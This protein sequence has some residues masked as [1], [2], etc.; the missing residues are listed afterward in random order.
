MYQNTAQGIAS[1]GRN[2]DSMLVHMTPGEVGGLQHLA[3]AHGGSLTINPQTGLPE[4]G[5]LSNILPIAASVIDSMYG[6]PWLG[7]AI[8]G[9]ANYLQTGNLGQSIG[10]GALSYGLGQIGSGMMDSG[11]TALSDASGV[12]NAF[13]NYDPSLA[14]TPPDASGVSL[15]PQFPDQ[16]GYA[17]YQPEPTVADF[18]KDAASAPV[19]PAQE[20]QLYANEALTPGPTYTSAAEIRN[21]RPLDAFTKGASKAYDDGLGA[22]LTKN[23]TPLMVAGAGLLGSSM[24][25]TPKGVN[26]PSVNKGTIRP[27]KRITGEVNP[28]W[29]KPGNQ[30]PYY[31]GEGYEAQPIYP[32]AAGG[33]MSFAGG[34]PATGSAYQTAST[35]F[36]DDSAKVPDVSGL[37]ISQLERLSTDAE[38]AALQTAARDRLFELGVT[39]RP[40][41]SAYTKHAAHGGLMDLSNEYAAGGRLLKGPGDGMS[42]SIPA[43]I[44]GPRPQRAALAQGEFV[45]PADVVSHLGNGS[46]DA[47]AKRLYAMMDKI[48]H[49]RTGNKKQGRQINPDKFM[50]A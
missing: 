32:A 14:I 34:G 24:F 19:A 36:S 31:I 8:S 30:N 25:E 15:A 16:P 39:Q 29:G 49:A 7:A 21:E 3:M 50:P 18:Y 47:G 28:N 46:T 1:L 23:K 38:T 33:L 41:K 27:Y 12:A 43:V 22:F 2:N 26:A 13:S 40:S 45:I 42:D 35:M 20:P 4:A 44:K 5:F 10:K 17:N 11:A 48:R 6:M 9:G 37:S